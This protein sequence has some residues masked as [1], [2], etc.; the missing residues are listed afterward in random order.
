MIGKQTGAFV[1]P[2]RFQQGAA[3]AL[4]LFALVMPLS[5]A[6]ANR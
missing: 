6:L 4:A 2:Q 1:T 5:I 3:I